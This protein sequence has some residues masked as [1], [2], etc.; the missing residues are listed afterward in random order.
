MLVG[1]YAHRGRVKRCGEMHAEA[2]QHGT[3]WQQEVGLQHAS[4]ISFAI[5]K[6]GQRQRVQD[7]CAGQRDAGQERDINAAQV[8]SLR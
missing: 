8:C 3:V 2:G 7:G 5:R 6:L 1:G 4:R